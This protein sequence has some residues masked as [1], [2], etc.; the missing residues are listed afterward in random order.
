MALE[1]VGG[2]WEA[3]RA[4]ERSSE[5]TTGGFWEDGLFFLPG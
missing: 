2:A 1:L 4:L 3:W 5:L